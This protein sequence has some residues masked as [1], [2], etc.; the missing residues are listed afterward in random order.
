L[1]CRGLFLGEIDQHHSFPDR[2][3]SADKDLPAFFY[4]LVTFLDKIDEDVPREVSECDSTVDYLAIL[5]DIFFNAGS[6]D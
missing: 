2:R 6:N 5:Y 1:T 3:H 4:N